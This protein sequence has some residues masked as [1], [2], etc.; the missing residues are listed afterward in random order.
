MTRT[1]P[2]NLIGKRPLRWEFSFADF[3]SCMALLR[4]NLCARQIR[5]YLST[6]R[7]KR[8]EALR[9]PPQNPTLLPL[10]L[11]SSNLL[12]SR[13]PHTNSDSSLVYSVSTRYGDNDER[14]SMEEVVAPFFMS[15]P[16]ARSRPIG[17]LRPTVLSELQAISGTYPNSPWQLHHG[18][19]HPLKPTPS[20]V[21][22]AP[23]VNE[24]GFSLRSS[25]MNELVAKWRT[26]GLFSVPGP[27]GGAFF[28]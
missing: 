18:A 13:G 12:I 23:W 4:G 11:S 26:M 25:L 15:S 6:T 16:S 22:F 1:R 7:Q 20:W 17:F 5:T 24:G 2:R 8:P 14:S 21:S 10:V 3:E 19:S 27:L 9:L 28:H